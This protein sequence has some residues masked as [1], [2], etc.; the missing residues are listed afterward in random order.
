M[1]AG[2][3]CDAVAA[4]AGGSV[5]VEGR[6]VVVA[7]E[8]RVEVEGRGDRCAAAPSELAAVAVE[9]EALLPELPPPCGVGAVGG[10][11]AVAALVVA[12]LAGRAG[13]AG[14]G[15]EVAGGSEVA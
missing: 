6:E 11:F 10:G 7:G 12:A 15:M 9:A 8:S 5:A 13:A 4:A 2:R 3:V 14:S 1:C